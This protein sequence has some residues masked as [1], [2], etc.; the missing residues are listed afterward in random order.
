[1]V[2]SKTKEGL[3]AKAFFNDYILSFKYENTQKV[4]SSVVQLEYNEDDEILISG[5]EHGS[6]D[7][8]E[9]KLY[10][11]SMIGLLK[12]VEWNEGEI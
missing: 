6:H 9:F 4:I 5:C 11:M 12:R 8:K 7:C 1:M 2:M 10:K 3:I